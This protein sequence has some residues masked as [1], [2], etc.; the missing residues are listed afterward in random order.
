MQQVYGSVY[1]QDGS[2][3][4][5]PNTENQIV[6]TE[7]NN[8]AR[9]W[10][11]IQPDGRY[12]VGALPVGEYNV[13]IRI[14]DR[15]V[16]SE[17]HYYTTPFSVLIDN[18]STVQEIDFKLDKCELETDA[19]IY[20]TDIADVNGLTRIEGYE[21]GFKDRYFIDEETKNRG[22]KPNS[23]YYFSETN[24]PS[25]ITLTS[26]IGD[27]VTAVIYDI[28]LAKS[29]IRVG[30]NQWI[31]ISSLTLMYDL[32]SST[33]TSI[34]LEDMALGSSIRFR[35]SYNP[36]L[37]GEVEILI[38][39]NNN[40]LEVP[41]GKISG[42]IL[43]PD[44]TTFTPSPNSSV[45]IHLYRSGESDPLLTVPIDDEGKYM[46]EG[47]HSGKYKIVAEVS[48]SANPYKTSIPEVI[49]L[50]I[51]TPVVKNIALTNAQISGQITFPN[52]EP[53][54]PTDDLHVVVYYRQVMAY[55]LRV[56]P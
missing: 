5:S 51:E 54:T 47:L 6:F 37:N 34:R 29:R 49:N 3:F 19:T 33:P 23:F 21:R 7:K 15:A 14:R 24:G 40:Y 8:L 31:R 36:I 25:A 48:G 9:Y 26:E 50:Q 41:S 56:Y 52:G 53:I 45:Q 12:R 16:T 46:I 39:E 42:Q 11:N 13:S 43:T 35:I 1:N 30:P 38:I 18:L 10:F 20:V 2:Q 32:S 44:H 55:L 17:L 4:V 28:E 22:V 27:F